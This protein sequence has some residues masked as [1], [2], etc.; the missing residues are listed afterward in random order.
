[1]NIVDTRVFFLTF[2]QMHGPGVPPIPA[3]RIAED[4]AVHGNIVCKPDLW[5][6]CFSIELSSLSVDVVFGVVG[7]VGSSSRK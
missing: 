2:F 5:T 1:M 4:I 3:R 6:R 7:G